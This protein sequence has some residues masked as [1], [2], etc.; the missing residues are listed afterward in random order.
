[1]NK[2]LSLSERRIVREVIREAA[3]ARGM[4]LRDF[5]E[6]V[7]N[8]DE[9]CISEL[10]VA[11]YLH[12]KAS[13]I[14]VDRLREILQLILEFIRALIPILSLFLKKGRGKRG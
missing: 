8:G 14:D 2:K 9:E 10:S 5:L 7:D 11:L 3:E 4:R 1:M 13:E 12:P 6:A